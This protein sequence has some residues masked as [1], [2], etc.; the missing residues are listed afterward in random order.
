M[1]SP[2]SPYHG[3]GDPQPA[4]GASLIGSFAARENAE[5]SSYHCLSGSGH[6]LQ[7][8]DQVRVKA[9]DYDDL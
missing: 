5:V 4:N 6:A 3:R 9:S 1:I 2:D 7:P 8:D